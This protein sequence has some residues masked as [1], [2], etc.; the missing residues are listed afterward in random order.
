MV[1]S[2]R[3]FVALARRESEAEWWVSHEARFY[4]RGQT[5]NGQ[6]VCTS[7][8]VD[9]SVSIILASSLPAGIVSAFLCYLLF[10]RVLSEPDFLQPLIEATNIAR[11]APRRL[12]QAKALEDAL[13]NPAGFNRTAWTEW[14]GRWAGPERGGPEQEVVAQEE[15]ANE[16]GGWKY[17][18]DGDPHRLEPLSKEDGMSP[19]GRGSTLIAA[20]LEFG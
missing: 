20:Q 5:L 13:C 18:E 9:S 8:Q 1:T 4:S 7:S 11:A 16:D 17:V 10:H 6:G 15:E 12:L 14:G 2:V 19:L 3:G